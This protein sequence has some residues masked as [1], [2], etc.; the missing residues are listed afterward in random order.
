[1]TTWKQLSRPLRL[2][3]AAPWLL[4]TALASVASVPSFRALLLDPANQ[5]TADVSLSSPH[6]TG[7]LDAARLPLIYRLRDGTDQQPNGALQSQAGALYLQANVD[8]SN[9]NAYHPAREQWQLRLGDDG[10]A[11]NFGV[12]RLND[13]DDAPY[14][15]TPLL[16]VSD[17]G[18]AHLRGGLFVGFQQQG[19]GSGSAYTTGFPVCDAGGNLRAASLTDANGNTLLD[20]YSDLSVPGLTALDNGQ[21]YTSGTGT[22]Y[23]GC[24]FVGN[25]PVAD[26][27]GNLYANDTLYVSHSLG[28]W[29]AAPPFAQPAAPTTLAEVVALLHDYGFC[30]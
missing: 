19:Y 12:Y 8:P 1:M 16:Q 20:G 21:I 11:R 25:N 3:L 9:N 24:L 15:A 26:S 17:N 22:L 5:P 23:V 7:T 29:G 30:Q 27:T 14:P 2:L 28:V 13:S 10:T 4:L 6:W 18:D